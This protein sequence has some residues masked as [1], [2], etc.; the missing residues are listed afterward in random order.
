M[1]A[2]EGCAPTHPLVRKIIDT[3]RIR[4]MVRTPSRDISN[5][6]SSSPHRRWTD[7]SGS[8]AY[9]WPRLKPETFWKPFSA[10]AG[11][12][13]AWEPQIYT[14]SHYE[15]FIAPIR[16]STDPGKD[17]KSQKLRG[18]GNAFTRIFK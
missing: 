6:C 12:V 9:G 5:T 3:M 1:K 13:C 8:W 7:Y 15:R 10:S 14:T 16:S 18:P 4:N 17:R 11:L 2:C